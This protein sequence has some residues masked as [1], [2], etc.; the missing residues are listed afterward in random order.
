MDGSAREI[1]GEKMDHQGLPRTMRLRVIVVA[2]SAGLLALLMLPL[3]ILAVTS[4]RED[5]GLLA[6]AFGLGLGVPILFGLLMWWQVRRYRR[7]PEVRRRQPNGRAGRVLLFGNL[8]AVVLGSLA[9]GISGIEGWGGWAV[10]LCVVLIASFLVVRIARHYDPR[11]HYF[12]R[13]DPLPAGEEPR[14][15]PSRPSW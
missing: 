2:V 1:R 3:E 10:G 7:N 15:E 13:P 4:H 12:R 9:R 5:L 14:D 6:A 11:I 8:V